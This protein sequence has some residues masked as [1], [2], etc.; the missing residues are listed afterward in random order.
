MW[1]P[2]R[3]SEV[4]WCTYV[5]LKLRLTKRALSTFLRLGQ[6]HSLDIQ[7]IHFLRKRS[8]KFKLTVWNSN[9][10]NDKLLN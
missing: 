1:C 7:L 2:S 8:H 10:Y 9:G 5:N 4:N 6:S 3:E